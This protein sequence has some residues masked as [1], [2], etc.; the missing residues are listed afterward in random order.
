M[1]IEVNR[2]KNLEEIE[3][4]FQHEDPETEVVHQLSVSGDTPIKL[5]QDQIDDW[6]NRF[7]DFYKSEVV[8]KK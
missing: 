1:T 3:I 2:G 6:E 7:G 8:S 4:V 5:A